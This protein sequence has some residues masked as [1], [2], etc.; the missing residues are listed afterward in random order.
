[1]KK[2]TFYKFTMKGFNSDILSESTEEFQVY[3]YN[4]DKC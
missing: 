1:M 2:V 4:W 3:F